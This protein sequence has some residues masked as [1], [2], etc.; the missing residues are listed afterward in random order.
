MN[1]LAYPALGETVYEDTLPNGLRIITVKK[2]G[3]HKTLAMFA[4]CYGG[5][6]RRFRLGDDWIDTPA[7]VAHFLEHK[8]FDM[9]D[10]SNAL[11]TLYAKGATAN[12]F[13]SSDMTAYLF[14]IFRSAVTDSDSAVFMQ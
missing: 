9:S 7:G 4:T 1:V 10:G 3:F 11:T 12:A 14:E 5:A 8:M 13:T 6:D 2:P